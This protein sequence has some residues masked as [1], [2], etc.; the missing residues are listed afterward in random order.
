MMLRTSASRPIPL[1]LHDEVVAKLR[2]MIVRCE[3][4]PGSRVPERELCEQLGI[5]RTPMREALKV[6]A[7]GGLVELWPN[8]GA[9]VA[10]LDAAEVADVFDLLAILE[11]RAGELAGRRL[12]ARGIAALERLHRR[13]MGHSAQDEREQLIKVDLQIHR[14]IVERAGSPALLSVHHE[15][16]A[17]VERARYLVGASYERLHDAMEEHQRIMDAVAD[18]NAERLAEEL[19][20]HSVKTR[21]AVVAAVR[22]RIAEGVSG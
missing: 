16:A 1:R 2:S 11:R 8:R 19:H 12:D 13:M 9:R 20:A 15:L 6:L 18:R 14:E 5:S 10:P 4:L 22:S 21:D 3:L 17:K 7:A